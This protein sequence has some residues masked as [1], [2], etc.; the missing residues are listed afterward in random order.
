MGYCSTITACLGIRIQLAKL[1]PQIQ[2]H[3]LGFVSQL[4]SKGFVEDENNDLNLDYIDIG[5]YGICFDDSVPEIK[6]YLTQEFK[7]HNLMD[8]YL[9]SPMK[10]I[11]EMR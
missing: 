7:S 9:L 8:K 1:I 5:H 11:L 4:M 3:N 2:P 10:D 6:D